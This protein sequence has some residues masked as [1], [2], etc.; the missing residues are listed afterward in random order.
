MWL[1]FEEV[2]VYQSL[3]TWGMVFGVLVPE[4]GASGGLV[5]IE[6]SLAGVIPDPVEA[7]V[8]CL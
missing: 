7:H 4:V 3:M 2:S 5:N 1:V 6:V 8:N